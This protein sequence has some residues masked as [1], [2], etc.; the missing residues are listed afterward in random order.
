MKPAPKVSVFIPTYNYGAFLDEAIQSIL[1]QTFTDYEL[2]IVDNCS[3]DNTEELVQKYL[4]DPRVSYY[5]NETNVGLVGNW[6]RCLELVRGEYLKMLCADDRLHPQLLEKFVRVMDENPQ[7]AIVGSHCEAFGDYS[8]CRVSP[9]V[10]LVTGNYVRQLLL[11]DV[12]VLRNPTVTMFR[13]K[14]A[15]KAGKFHMQLKK[16]ADREYYMRLLNLGDCYVV[17]DSLSYVRQ[18]TQRESAKIKVLKYNPIFE[19]YAFIESV[20]KYSR[21][22]DPLLPQINAMMRQRAVRCAAVM[23]QVLPGFYKE[24]NRRALKAA[25]QIGSSNNVVLAPIPHYL[26]WKFVK[27]LFTREKPVD[28]YKEVYRITSEQQGH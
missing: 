5:K 18:H 7:V 26:Q 23:Y 13:N 25:Y 3:T 19:N 17:P 11:G 12:N 24:D 22:K 21:E 14:D 10:G 2:I 1:G 27:K 16:L 4:T 6:N 20:K 9:F 8:F 28:Y 15:K